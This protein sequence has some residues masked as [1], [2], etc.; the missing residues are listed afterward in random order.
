MVTPML[1]G[2]ETAG[3]RRRRTQS[4]RGKQEGGKVHF[5]GAE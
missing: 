5:E 4:G 2:L 1:A 3:G